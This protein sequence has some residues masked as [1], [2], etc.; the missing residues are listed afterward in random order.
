MRY[1]TVTE[2]QEGV[3][4]AVRDRKSQ[5]WN[6]RRQVKRFKRLKKAVDRWLT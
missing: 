3:L 5:K 1:F 6:R 2:D 4:L